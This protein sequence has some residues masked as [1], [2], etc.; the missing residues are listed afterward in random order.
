MLGYHA[1][2]PALVIWNNLCD[3]VYELPTQSYRNQTLVAFDTKG[4]QAP[5]SHNLLD[6]K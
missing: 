5:N 6:L 3:L 4:Y 1:T 2:P